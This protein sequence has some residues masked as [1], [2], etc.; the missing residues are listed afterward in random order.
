MEGTVEIGESSH[1]APSLFKNL[2]EEETR[3]RTKY[4]SGIII[5]SVEARIDALNYAGFK[6]GWH[7]VAPHFN[8][9]DDPNIG[10]YT[11]WDRA[12]EE[13]LGNNW[14]AMKQLLH[15]QAEDSR[16]PGVEDEETAQALDN[17]A[18]SL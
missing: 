8:T 17:M 14:V 13:T 12:T 15:K 6:I 2:L 7:R 18:N 16:K 4:G 9:E 5:N 11:D 10:E 3:I 1:A